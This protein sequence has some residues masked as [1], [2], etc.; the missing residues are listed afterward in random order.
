MAQQLVLYIQSQF[1]DSNTLTKV[2][3]YKDEKVSLT[4]TLQDIR[5]IEKV[6]TDFTQP[7]TLPASDENNRLFQHWYNPDIVGYN[8]NFRSPAVLEL[9]YLPFRKGFITL[10]SVKMRDGNPEFYNITFL[11]ETVDLKNVISEDQLD[12]LTWLNSTGFLFTND[13]NSA[14]QGLN[15]GLDK[16]VDGVLYEN[17]FVYPLV[18]HSVAF[19]YVSNPNPAILNY[20]NLWSNNSQNKSGVY[21]NDLKPAIKVDL[22]LKAIEETYNLKFSTDFFFTSA[23][24]N[25]YLWMSR[26]KGFMTGG[27]RLD[28]AYKNATCS[29]ISGLACD[30]FGG[31]F[32]AQCDQD[33]QDECEPPF[34]IMMFG[35]TVGI[36]LNSQPYVPASDP[37]R[38]RTTWD[39]TP[40]SSSANFAFDWQIF[41]NLNNIVMSSQDGAIG[42]TQIIIQRGNQVGGTYQIQTSE[43]VSDNYNAEYSLQVQS[44]E[45]FEFDLN[46]K[47]EA[48]TR[49]AT[50]YNNAGGVG[51]VNCVP[52]IQTYTFAANYT[53]NIGTF[54]LEVDVV[55]TEQLPE[56][57]TLDFLTGL[58]KT[59]NLTAFFE[60][61]II[62]VK[63][64]DEFYSASTKT[65]DLTKTVHSDK[66]SVDEALPFSEV[67]FLYAEPKTI[68]AQKFEQLN[69]RRY[70]ELR[71][72]AD[73][74]KQGTY[75]IQ[76]PFEHMVYERIQDQTTG[77]LT[78]LQQGTFL[79]D[80]LN[81]SFGKPLLFYA[82]Y[83]DDTGN[84]PINWVNGLRPQDVTQE[85]QA[86]NR[87]PFN[88]Y[89]TVSNAISLGSPTVAPAI[90]L[91]FGSEVNTWSLTDY[92]GNNNSLFQNYYQNYI[93]RVFDSRNRLFKFKVKLP[94]D[95]LL[96]FSLA[97]TIKIGN[98][99]FTINK[100][101][102]DLTTGES[103]ME[104]LNIF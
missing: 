6:R 102:A 83:N 93:T 100:V 43:L 19:N 14:R 52:Y 18:S 73:A 15:I 66:H 33:C 22:I 51:D 79:D 27:G 81:A 62:V 28:T 65:W 97:D 98:R 61:G 80:N 78:T 88:R 74:S 85:P 38:W 90:S 86:G 53:P 95:F 36:S 96:N 92:G 9:N 37:R 8:S 101:T 54:I 2:D 69:N 46:I 13:N 41:D 32:D 45:A 94:L 82:V 67:N 44:A 11:G 1:N 64:L 29:N 42:N 12:Q 56:I 58:F 77:A 4:M 84:T 20:T 30:F 47:M 103:T 76:S 91:N 49:I 17:A 59:Y 75:K 35:L 26:N 68:I 70:G 3:M 60:D 50:L 39:I 55:P 40:T 16:T 7:F 72:V 71:Y 57:K 24:E 10:N 99:E 25:L 34:E 89:W 31:T 104:L 87:Q 48:Q 23:T 21:Y 63:P 5:D